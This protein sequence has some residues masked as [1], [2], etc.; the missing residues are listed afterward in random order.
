APAREGLFR[1]MATEGRVVL[2]NLFSDPSASVPPQDLFVADRARIEDLLAALKR[3]DHPLPFVFGRYFERFSHAP[4]D[5]RTTV[6][7]FEALTGTAET[8]EILRTA[9]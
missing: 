4:F 2:P 5:A 8:T 6:A 9:L 7:E 1:A 3:L